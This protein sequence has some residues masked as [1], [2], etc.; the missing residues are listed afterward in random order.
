MDEST[1]K[2]SAM[3]QEALAYKQHSPIYRPTNYAVKK[4]P[5]PYYVT[6]KSD[7]RSL[8]VMFS[9]LATVFVLTSV[10][11]LCFFAFKLY[12]FYEN[13]EK[14]VVT[15]TNV[16]V[17]FLTGYPG[18]GTDL[19]RR[20]LNSDPDMRCG[21]GDRTI[22]AFLEKQSY[23]DEYGAVVLRSD[24][25]NS[26][27]SDDSDNFK[28]NDLADYA[29]SLAYV[30]EVLVAESQPSKSLCTTVLDVL[31]HVNFLQVILPKAKYL[32]V[33]R[34]GR[35]IA[36]AALSKEQKTNATE[37]I[38]H[39]ERWNNAMSFLMTTCRLMGDQR[40]LAV[41]YEELVIRPDRVVSIVGNFLGLNLQTKPMDGPSD[42]V[43]LHSWRENTYLRNI[44]QSAA[45]NVTWLNQLGYD[46]EGRVNYM[47][48]KSKNLNPK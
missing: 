33:V 46:I 45:S 30:L 44:H 5:V 2:Y 42:E 36:E 24:S 9:V 38:A 43:D 19:L 34:D 47:K 3:V 7:R 32:L 40:C 39:M 35:A 4:T 21:E 14:V 48:L 37:A 16:P 26:V 41:Y 8:W 10:V 31:K 29:A 11:F 28:Q 13:D 23:P 22:P 20:I 17:V 25:G 15:D 18:S 27:T 6:V 12:P 1:L